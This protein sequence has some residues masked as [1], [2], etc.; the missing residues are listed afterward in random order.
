MKNDRIVTIDGPSGVGKSTV[1][2]RVAKLLG[3]SYLDTGAMYRAVALKASEKG[4]DPND[5]EA[6]LDMISE[7]AVEFGGEGRILL[8]S[9][10]VSSLI[11]MERIS[12]L[13]SK[14]A[15]IGEVREFLVDVQR[16]IGRRGNM[17]AEGR[18]M[19]TYVFP[20]ARHKFYLDASLPERARRRFLQS[21]AKGLAED[22]KQVERAL[23]LRD[24]RDTLRS[25]NPLHPAPDAVIIDTTRLDADQVVSQI[26]SIAKD[27]S[28]CEA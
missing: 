21:R 11:R 6:L 20:W 2:A 22:V 9:R 18:D 10:D 5:R 16:K 8:D 27:I 28:A 13:S 12:S 23:R 1:A 26:A 4:I 19:G 7:T 24:S 15:E 14:L 17:V 25:R 3:F